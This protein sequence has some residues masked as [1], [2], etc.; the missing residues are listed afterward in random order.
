MSLSRFF[1][2]SSG[3]QP[4][5]ILDDNKVVSKGWQDITSPRPSSGQPFTPSSEIIEKIERGKGP[6]PPE[7]L[8]PSTPTEEAPPPEPN[9]NNNEKQQQLQ[10]QDNHQPVVP[11]NYISVGD[12]EQI[13]QQ[14]YDQGYIEGVKAG[15]AQAANKQETDFTSATNAM[16]LIC[17]QLETCRDTIINNSSKELQDFAI[18]IAEKVIRYSVKHHDQTIIATIEEALQRSIKSSEFYIYVNPEDYDIVAEKSE[19]LIAGVSGLNNIVIKKDTKIER[20]G[21]RIESENCTVDAT[22]ASQFDLIREEVEKR[23]S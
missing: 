7:K 22:I 17:N 18:A 12:V 23:I 10:E 4:Q 6:K 1:K 2:N 16:M 11:E 21:T 3:F 15:E 19:E 5:T 9:I 8:I 20:G 13:K 14:A